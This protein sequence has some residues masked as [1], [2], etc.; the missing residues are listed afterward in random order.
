[1]WLSNCYTTVSD[2]YLSVMVSGYVTVM[3]SLIMQY[4]LSEK[5]L[6]SEKEEEW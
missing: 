2:G 3:V 4:Q 5:A 1:M 6:L